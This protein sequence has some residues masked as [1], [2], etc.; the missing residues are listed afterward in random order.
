MGYFDYELIENCVS[1]SSVYFVNNF[2]VCNI[3]DWNRYYKIRIF[4]YAYVSSH[5]SLIQPCLSLYKCTFI[6][7]VQI[8]Q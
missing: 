3:L 2:R 1:V 8:L 7:S 5:V 4:R 6:L